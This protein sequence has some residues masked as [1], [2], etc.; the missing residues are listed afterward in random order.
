VL[1][2][3]RGVVYQIGF[4][5]FF[6]EGTVAGWYY[7]LMQEILRDW[8]DGCIPEDVFVERTKIANYDRIIFGDGEPAEGK[9]FDV[10]KEMGLLGDE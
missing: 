3:I 8:K 10:V 9:L 4:F 5:L 6:K 1:L 2:S 7:E